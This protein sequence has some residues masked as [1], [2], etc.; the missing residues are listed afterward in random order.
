MLLRQMGLENV[1]TFANHLSRNV[2]T[3]KKFRQVPRKTCGRKGM[4]GVCHETAT[5]YASVYTYIK[6]KS[7]LDEEASDVLRSLV[8]YEGIHMR[9]Q[10]MIPFTLPSAV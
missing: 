5:K 3:V 7:E 9:G 4:S 8:A 6:K 2:Y 1:F 10:K